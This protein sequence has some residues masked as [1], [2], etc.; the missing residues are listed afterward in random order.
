MKNLIWILCLL[1]LFTACVQ[2]KVNKKTTDT[3]TS[4]IGDNNTIGCEETIGGC[5]SGTPT[6]TPTSTP[7]L[8]PS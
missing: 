5:A 8:D 7:L 3:D 1:G 4:P 6:A 2:K